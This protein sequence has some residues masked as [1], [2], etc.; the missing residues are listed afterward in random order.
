M[1]N[2]YDFYLGELLSYQNNSNAI[3]RHICSFWALEVKIA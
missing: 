1:Y 3:A 2:I